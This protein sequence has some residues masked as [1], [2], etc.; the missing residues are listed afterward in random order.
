MP[1]ASGLLKVVFWG[2][3]H[4]QLNDETTAIYCSGMRIGGCNWNWKWLKNHQFWNITLCQSS[5]EHHRRRVIEG[6]WIWYGRMY[7]PTISIWICCLSSGHTAGLLV[8]I[9]M[10]RPASCW[11]G[12]SQV[13][14]WCGSRQAELILHTLHVQRP[15]PIFILI[16]CPG[17]TLLHVHFKWVS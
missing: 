10:I 3:D 2:D 15:T 4:I 9:G 1:H 8:C 11:S 6:F 5:V 13:K 16:G 17:P 14:K 7:I 12:I